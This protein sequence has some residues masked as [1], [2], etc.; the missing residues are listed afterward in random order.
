[1]ISAHANPV[2]AENRRERF[3]VIQ[4]S[5]LSSY[6]ILLEILDANNKVMNRYLHQ[7]YQRKFKAESANDRN[8]IA[9]WY[10]LDP[11][12]AFR[13]LYSLDSLS[14]ALQIRAWYLF[15]KTNIQNKNK[16]YKRF[17]KKKQNVF[18]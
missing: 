18:Y 16:S 4:Y 11:E 2:E 7:N 8:R 6:E 3:E 14:V 10:F 12:V 9:E 5:E 13:H 1:M 15:A 17:P